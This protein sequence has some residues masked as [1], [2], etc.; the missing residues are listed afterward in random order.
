[1]GFFSTTITPTTF[2]QYALSEKPTITKVRQINF[3]VRSMGTS[4]YSAIGG[5]DSQN[6]RLTSVGHSISIS[7]V[8]PNQYLDIASLRIISD[9]A[10]A[11]IEIFGEAD[12]F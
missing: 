11:L 7:P 2:P 4:T 9:T 1:M 12:M 5:I 3:A 8:M 6:R 10:D